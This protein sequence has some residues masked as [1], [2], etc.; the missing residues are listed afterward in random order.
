MGGQ[1][2]S[3]GE[4]A[5]RHRWLCHPSQKTAQPC[6][7]HSLLCV[8]AWKLCINQAVVCCVFVLVSTDFV[9]GLFG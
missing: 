7:A 8:Q 6:A 2:K 1:V 9:W 3:E 5:E 4:L